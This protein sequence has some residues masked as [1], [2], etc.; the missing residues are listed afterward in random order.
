MW[1][2]CRCF[3]P[4]PVLRVLSKSS[5]AN[6]YDAAIKRTGISRGVEIEREGEMGREEE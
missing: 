5:L 1:C 4:E 6:G 3:F 2:Y